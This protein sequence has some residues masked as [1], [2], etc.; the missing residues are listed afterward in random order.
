VFVARIVQSLLG[1]TSKLTHDWR[2]FFAVR[3]VPLQS[4]CEV[5]LCFGAPE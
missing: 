2:P 5:W 1:W 4:R 3:A